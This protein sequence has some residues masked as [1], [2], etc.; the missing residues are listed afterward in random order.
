MG[1]GP[2]FLIRVG[3]GQPSMVWVWKISPKNG[4]Y[5]NFFLRVGSKSTWVEGGSASYLLQVKSKLR[6]GPISSGVTAR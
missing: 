3:S 4:K 1:P 6:S 5:F 2:K